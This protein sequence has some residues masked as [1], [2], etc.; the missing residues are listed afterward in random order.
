MC[1]VLKIEMGTI[2]AS[3]FSVF[4]HGVVLFHLGFFLPCSEDNLDYG[5]KG[6]NGLSWYNL[7][8]LEEDS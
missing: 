1:R 7:K 4:K 8:G 2:M 5:M 6:L 3:L